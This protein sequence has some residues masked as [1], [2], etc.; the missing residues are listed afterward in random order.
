MAVDD[1][2][3]SLHGRCSAIPATQLASRSTR[4]D[5]RGVHSMDKWR[6]TGKFSVQEDPEGFLT[7][8]FETG[9]NGPV[10]AISLRADSTKKGAD[11]LAQM[12]NRSTK[13]I[14]IQGLLR[15]QPAG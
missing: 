1:G 11:E 12:I 14:Q 7:L 13:S 9:G 15:R 4:A 3:R 10:V 5:R 6:L 8:N 2:G